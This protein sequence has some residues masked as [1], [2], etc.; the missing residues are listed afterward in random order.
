MDTQTQVERLIELAIIQRAELKRLVEELPQLREHLNAE[1]ERTFEETEPQLRAELEE[2][3]AKQAEDKTSALGVAL[4]ARISQLA[5]TLQDSAQ[6]K[7]SA[8]MA[9]REQNAEL[10]KIAEGKIAEA[11]AAL[12]SNVKEI[13]TAELARFPRAGEIDKLR[14]EFA[15]P[16]GLNPR[17][18]WTS[19]ETYNK[20][21]LVSYN[22]DSFVSSVDGNTEKPSRTSESW[23]LSAARGGYGGGGGI[24]SLIDLYNKPDNGEVLIGNGTDFVKNTLTAGTGITITNGAGT[25][26]ID[27]TGAQETLTATVTNAES[28]PITRGQVV[29]I[30]GATGNRPSVK[31]ASNASEATS[32]KTFGVV[33]DASIAANGIGTVTCVGVVDQLSLGSYS[34]GA[35][36][37]LGSTAGTFTA[38]KPAAPNHLVYVG[39]VQR[40]NNGNGQLYVKIQNGYELDEIHDV[41][42]NAPKQAGQTLIYDATNSLWKNARLTAGVGVSITNADSSITIS[43]DGGVNYQGTWNASTNSPALT[44]SVGTKGFYYVVSVAGSTNLNGITDWQVGDW[45]IFNGSAWQKVDTTDQ[46][47]S[48]FGR[49][50]AVVGVSTDYSAVGITNTAIGAS[51][52]STGAFTTLSASTSLT[53]PDVTLGTNGPSVKSSLDARAARQGLVFDGTAGSAA[54]LASAIGTSDVT[55][56]AWMDIPSSNPSLLVAY[57]LSTGSAWKPNDCGAYINTDGTLNFQLRGT[58]V[59]DTRVATVTANAVSTWG[60]KRILFTVRRTGATLSI[61]VNGVSQSFTIAGSAIT[62]ANTIDGTALRLGDLTGNSYP[63]VGYLSLLIYNR[64]LSASEVVSLFEAGVPA[65]ADYGASGVPASNT[66][67]VTGANSDFSSDTGYWSKSGGASITGGKLV[68]AGG[69]NSYIS[70]GSLLT[71]GK[72]YRITLTISG[73]TSGNISYYDGVGISSFPNSNG[74]YS[75]EV[76]AAGTT[77]YLLGSGTNAVMSV[78]DLFIYPIGLL[79][80]PDAAQ[81]GGGLAWYD[82][83]GNAANITLPASGVSWNVPSSQKT[84]SG[85]TYSGN[86][87]VRSA[88][89]YAT[90]IHSGATSDS[91]QQLILSSSGAYNNAYIG[92]NGTNLGIGFS[93]TNNSFTEDNAITIAAA[94]KAVTLAGNLTVSGSG[95]ATINYST[96]QSLLTM[97]DAA[98]GSY[99]RIVMRT[100]ATRV[101]WSIGAQD[102]IN[103]ALT[104]TA[105]TAAGGTTFTTPLMTLNS[106]GNL[107]LNSTGVDSANGKLQLASSSA[108]S[109][110]IG[111]GTDT[112]LYRVYNGEIAIDHLGGTNPYLWLRENNIGRGFFSTNSGNVELG[113]ATAGNSVAIKSGAS[114]T[115][116]TLDSSQI[117]N[118]AGIKSQYRSGA[119]TPAIRQCLTYSTTAAATTVSKK[120]AYVG[121]SHSLRVSVIAVQDGSLANVATFSGFLTTSYGGTASGGTTSSVAGAITAITV[122]YDNSGSPSYTINVTLTYT[123]N[124]PVIYYTIDGH[125]FNSI[126][127]I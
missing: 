109:G 69:A 25:I 18:K 111:F 101:A 8:I 78:D 15:E 100:G 71:V 126:Y 96:A 117:A 14:K 19:G 121:A 39:I 103:N 63:F 68:F 112:A 1:V 116:L 52:P 7:F 50:G 40:A 73:Y 120:I 97:G 13:V 56:A 113:T 16:R 30:F 28:V 21:D 123:G 4:E 46:V 118:F 41:Q 27:A 34:E 38:T 60:G 83:S 87:N 2:F 32:S 81:A 84:A 35:T 36:V 110:G 10:L 104:F 49:T 62:W 26:T 85:W 44:S 29:Y 114:V 64:A 125:S 9:A 33:S 102:L 67:I 12:P 58:L 98:V 43:A 124:A 119:T 86:L 91:T 93:S 42:I 47:S 24:T 94:T 89:G 80:A 55:F 3:V 5:K 77:F 75:V 108:V 37:Y 74:T 31:L 127:E 90:G 6:A 92:K 48:V 59:G 79:L 95:G 53:T 23:T 99:S 72:K 20:L 66:S 51:N 88:L 105:S 76:T 107:L 70:R 115:A 11:A 22:G 65:G 122:A 45:A 82:T 54:T 106:D 57:Y 61:E 17:G